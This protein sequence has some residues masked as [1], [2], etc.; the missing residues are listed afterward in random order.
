MSQSHQLCHS[1]PHPAF[2]VIRRASSVDLLFACLLS[3]SP[4]ACELWAPV[5]RNGWTVRSTE[6]MNECAAAVA[7]TSKP[8]YHVLMFGNTR[9]PCNLSKGLHGLPWLQNSAI[10]EHCF[11]FG[12]KWWP[13]G[14]NL[15]QTWPNDWHWMETLQLIPDCQTE[16]CS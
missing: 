10:H 15:G 3:L 2:F 11:C 14:F 6:E 5:P 12:R 7:L 13:S 9:I 16:L 8:C 4:R 1:A